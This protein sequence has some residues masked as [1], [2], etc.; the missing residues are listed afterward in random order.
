MLSNKRLDMERD[1]IIKI[2]NTFGEQSGEPNTGGGIRGFYEY[3]SN[4]QKKWILPFRRGC[5]CYF[6]GLIFMI[7]DIPL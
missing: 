1:F 3:I 7:L 4:S 2:S 6:N 5:L